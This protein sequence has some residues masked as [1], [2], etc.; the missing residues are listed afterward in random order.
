MPSSM[1]MIDAGL[2]QF[3]GTEKTE[4]KVAAIQNY[5]FM[6]L[7]ELQYVLRNLGE[8]NFNTQS[9]DD[10]KN[11]VAD[12]VVKSVKAE[13]IISNTVITNELYANYGEIADLTV[14]QL[15]TD[16]ARVRNY[17]RGD[18]GDLNYL[19]AHDEKIDFITASVASP[20]QEE[21]L[22]RDGRR[23]YWKDGSQTQMTSTEQTEWPVMVYVYD[24]L[25]KASFRF[26]QIPM[27]GGYTYAPRLVFGAGDPAGNSKGYVYKDLNGLSVVYRQSGTGNLLK[28]ELRDDGAY[29][30]GVKVEM[31]GDI[32]RVNGIGLKVVDDYPETEKSNVLYIKLE[33]AAT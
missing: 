17:L 15:R 27:G 7:E 4:D 21:Q 33:E 31:D 1:H 26:D 20:L 28:L 19:F 30:N 6:L 8:E 25:V 32:A 23:F 22:Q 16:Y 14:W 18:V 11:G 10:L 12:I 3:T 2:P 9:L 13:T 29:L 5:L 24:E